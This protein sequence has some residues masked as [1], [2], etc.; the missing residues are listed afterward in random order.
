MSRV[1]RDLIDAAGG[2]HGNPS[3][4]R[5]LLTFEA[6]QLHRSDS[7]SRSATATLMVC[8]GIFPCNVRYGIFPSTTRS[9]RLPCGVNK[10]GFLL[11]TQ[12]NEKPWSITSPPTEMTF[13]VSLKTNEVSSV[14]SEQSELTLTCP[15]ARVGP[16]AVLRTTGLSR[17][18]ILP[19]APAPR[20]CFSESKWCPLP[21]SMMK[22]V[23]PKITGE[24]RGVDQAP[25]PF[26]SS[27]GTRC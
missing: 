14:S 4:S 25:L 9:T 17:G 3:I 27:W 21:V 16:L 20:T 19:R 5:K 1:V 23:L 26:C 12:K 6:A 18:S 13:G 15:S 7:L 24:L 2:T 11:G 8:E 22:R 10:N